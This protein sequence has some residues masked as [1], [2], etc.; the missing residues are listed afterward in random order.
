MLNFF[1]KIKLL[2]ARVVELEVLNNV[3]HV[4]IDSLKNQVKI[5][6]Q[7]SDGWKSAAIRRAAE[8]D[9]KELEITMLKVELINARAA[10]KKTKARKKK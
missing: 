4:D 6:L 8:L 7:Y 5:G 2:Q 1:K 9:K 10:A 3:L